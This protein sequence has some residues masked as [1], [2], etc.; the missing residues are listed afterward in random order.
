MIVLP[1]QCLENVLL[2]PKGSGP[3]LR[4][5]L[6]QISGS[7]A[8]RLKGTVPKQPDIAH[9]VDLTRESAVAPEGS[10]TT[11]DQNSLG[12]VVEKAVPPRDGEARS[13]VQSSDIVRDL[14]SVQD[15]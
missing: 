2:E 7:R 1:E 12:F 14:P 8:I 9:H 10:R 5:R 4:G 11:L 6:G 15:L 13:D 3:Q